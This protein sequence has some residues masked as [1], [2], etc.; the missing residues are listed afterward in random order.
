MQLVDIGNKIVFTHAKFIATYSGE[1]ELRIPV[2]S[3]PPGLS[4]L[5]LI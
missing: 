5:V 3:E 4:R 2:E 1:S